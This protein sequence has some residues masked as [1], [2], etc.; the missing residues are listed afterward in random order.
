M[1]RTKTIL[2]HLIAWA[3][4]FLTLIFG[5]VKLDG[6]F[7][8]SFVCTNIPVVMLFYCITAFVFPYFLKKGK[9][10]LLA[11]S[12]IVFILFSVI[13]RFILAMIILNSS[14][15]DLMDAAISPM[16][17]S[18]LRISLL[19]TGISFAVWYARRNFEMTKNQQLLEKE[20]ADAQLLTLKNQINPHFLYNT[21]SFLYTKS[22]PLSTELSDAIA[23]LS[24]M[25]RYS[26]GEAGEDGMVSLQKEVNHLKNF[27]NIHQLRYDNNLQ[28]QFNADGNIE[29]HK[30]IPLLLITFVENAFKH[31]NVS[32]KQYPLTIQL[33]ANNTS[34]QFS[35]SNKKSKGIKEKSSGVGL[36]NIK[37]RLALAYPEKHVLKIE[38]NHEFYAINLTIQN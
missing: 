7:W 21:L 23:A 11:L 12:V 31:G 2:V 5:A 19:F 26:L 15:N 9:Y 38:D 16:F 8:I 27:I 35:V 28:I 22:L 37:N 25:M 17:W 32:D 29:K 33:H 10:G 1:K 24:E 30:I 20:I 34:M 18:Q 36:Q 14:L 6:N 3:I 4:Y 13:L